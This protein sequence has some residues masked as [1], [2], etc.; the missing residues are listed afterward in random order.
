MI[1]KFQFR[2]YIKT[3][4]TIINCTLLIYDFYVALF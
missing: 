4:T 1:V 3:N 2:P